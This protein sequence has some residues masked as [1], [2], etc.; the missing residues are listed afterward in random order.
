MLKTKTLVLLLFSNILFS[1]IISNEAFIKGNNVEVGVNNCGIF[2]TDN[3]AP[4]SFH[5]RNNNSQRNLGFVADPDQDGWNVGTPNYYGD[6]FYP[7]RPQEGFSLQFNNA[8][9]HNWNAG[10]KDIKGTNVSIT[11]VES[12]EI[13]LWEGTIKGLRIRQKTIVPK[14]Q[15]FFIVRVELTNT[16]STTMNNVYYLRTLDPD[17]EITLSGSYDTKNDILYTLPNTKNNTLVSATGLSYTNCFLGLGTK[18]CR[19]KPFIINNSLTP[20]ENDLI[21]VIHNRTNTTNYQYT[22]TQTYDTG[23]GISYFIGNIAP[24]E[25]KKLAFT[26]ILKE[27]DL[28][29][30]LE[31]TLPEVSLNS[32]PIIENS[33][34]NKC[35]NELLNLSVQNGDDYLWH[36]EPEEYFATP[37]GETNVLTLAPNSSV[38][39]K[40]TAQSNCS[41]ILLNFKVSTHPFLAPLKEQNYLLCSGNSTNYDPF[42]NVTSP[43]SSIKWYDAA[44]GGTIIGTSSS[45]TTPIL[46]NPSA[47]PAEYVYYYVETTQNGCVSERIPFK[48][49]VFNT[50]ILPNSELRRCVIGST[51]TTFNLNDYI[52]NT[53]DNPKYTFY[54]SL[55][56]LN[57]DVPIADP[58]NYVNTVN[59][60]IIYVKVIVNS[61]CLDVAELTL[62]VFEQFILT[63][64]SIRGCDDDFDE[65]TT[66][67]LTSKN[68]LITSIPGTNFSYFLTNSNAQNNINEITNFTNYTNLTNPQIVYV[69]TYNANC[70]EITQLTLD[71]YNKTVVAP[72]TI[73]NCQENINGSANFN[74]TESNNSISTDPGLT[75]SYYA[76]LD[77]L[78]KN[79]PIPNFLSYENVTNPQTVF[80][81][82]MNP[83]ICFSIAELKLNVLPVTRHIITD[84]FKCDTDYDG[85]LNFDLSLKT[86]EISAILPLDTYTFTYYLSEK[87][88]FLETNAVPQN[89]VNV[90]SPQTI[91][92]KATGKNSCPFIINFNIIVLVKPILNINKN[93]TICDKSPITLDAG[94]GFDSYQ[95]ST[96][97]KTQSIEIKSD[98]DYTV[99]VSNNYGTRFCETE[100]T[101]TVVKSSIAT[102]DNIIINDW[103]TNQNSISVFVTGLGDYEYSLDN[104]NYQDSP[105]FDNLDIGVFR[106]YVRDKKGCGISDDE[107]YILN[108]PKYFT[109]NKDGY[110]DFWN[111]KYSIYEPNLKVSIYDRFGKF[112]TSFKGEDAGWDGT[113]SGRILPT[114]DYWFVVNRADGK[115]FKGHFTLKR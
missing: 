82:V 94:P 114:T 24:G 3:E 100:E 64:Q 88:A 98:G 107:I 61:I 17:N 69:R 1:Q 15:V 83:N 7:G 35:E 32:I 34:F 110:N 81:K 9:F 58:T 22:G 78:N 2:G 99:K 28:E 80:V 79:I 54:S 62:R 96:S 51:T 60:Q 42:A 40:V 41:S 16:T 102:I 8:V 115:V 27:S 56:N 46:T 12:N 112:I 95:W 65:K 75:F 48:V 11:T 77:N 89:Y 31:Q 38:N 71:V 33:N 93:R 92:I 73:T 91:Y 26:Y 44:V 52:E 4:L 10:R 21:E 101:I 53:F 55:D 37:Y 6:F 76:T 113:Y 74:L 14:N 36:W 20:I 105:D 25:T 97:E 49:S 90:S 13:S 39:F 109:P 104:L 59:N 108:Y 18:D 106:V 67:D 84:E 72:T 5:A 23:I 87:D 43:T 111:I 66:F 45:F 68:S 86:P 19:A 29:V 47:I 63:P 50:L 30:A 70:F 57:K 85:F 103:T